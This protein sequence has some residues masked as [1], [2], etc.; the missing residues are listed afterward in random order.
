MA[1]R[2]NSKVKAK[3]TRT[4]KAVKTTN[5]ELLVMSLYFIM[6]IKKIEFSQIIYVLI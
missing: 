4:K 3:K 1:F 5:H 2:T 6:E